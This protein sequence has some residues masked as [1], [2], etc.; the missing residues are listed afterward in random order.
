[1]L[2]SVSAVVD[3]FGQGFVTTHQPK[4]ADRFP[5]RIEVKETSMQTAHVRVTV[6]AA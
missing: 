2:E 4:V 6:V 5:V 3:E 1:V